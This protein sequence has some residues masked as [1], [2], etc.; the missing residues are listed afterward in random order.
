MRG[1]LPEAR[2]DE[3]IDEMKRNP[4]AANRA[5]VTGFFEHIAANGGELASR[6]ATTTTPVWLARGDSDEVGVTDAELAILEAAPNVSLK[7]IPG[8]AHFSITDRPHAVAQLV[9]E[10][11]DGPAAP[12]SSAR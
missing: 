4:R 1:R 7:T 8:A 3:L 6:L 2:F 12:S 5:Q 10:L 11:L 9:V